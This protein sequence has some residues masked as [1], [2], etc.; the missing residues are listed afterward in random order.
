MQV[1]SQILVWMWTVKQVIGGN[2]YGLVVMSA[3]CQRPSTSSLCVLFYIHPIRSRRHGSSGCWHSVL[4][5]HDFTCCVLSR[6]HARATSLSLS[7]SLTL[8]LPFSLLGFLLFIALLF[9]R[10]S[11]CSSVLFAHYL[12]LCISIEHFY[13]R[14]I[15]A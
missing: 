14:R 5:S 1:I 4:F 6:M 11:L 10:P 15:T 13:R 8:S 3:G 7:L 9:Y 12:H 2:I